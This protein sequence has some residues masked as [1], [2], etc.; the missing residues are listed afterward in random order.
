MLIILLFY[1]RRFLV[2]KKNVRACVRANVCRW[3]RPDVRTSNFYAR[4]STSKHE[5]ALCLW[6]AKNGEKNP[7]NVPERRAHRVTH[8]TR[9]GGDGG[10]RAG[11]TVTAA[12]SVM[13]PLHA[14]VA[15]A[16]DQPVRTSPVF[17]SPV[18]GTLR[19]RATL[20]LLRNA[21]LILLYTAL[22]SWNANF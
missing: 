4:Y 12:Y 14:A 20:P 5:P 18:T 15:V 16:A 22:L 6:N 9:S 19:A 10:R 3:P 21:I 11:P 8:K 1:V 13:P 17:R 2:L 7:D